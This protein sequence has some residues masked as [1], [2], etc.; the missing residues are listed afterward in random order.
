MFTLK[1]TLWAILLVSPFPPLSFAQNAVETHRNCGSMTHLAEQIAEHPELKTERERIEAQTYD[2]VRRAP[3]VS[4]RSVITIPVVVHVL[5]STAIEN[6]S[7]AQIQSQIDALNRDFRKINTEATRIPAEFQSVAADV[8]LEFCLAKR[9]PNGLPTSGIERLG[10]NKSSWKANDE[11]KR[12]DKGGLDPWDATKYLNIWVCSLNGGALGYAT[13]PGAP[14]SIDGVVIDYRYFG[15]FNTRAPFNLGRTATHEVGHWLNLFHIWGDG[16]C[17]DDHCDD[18]PTHQGAN[19]GCPTYPLVRT[20]C[21]GTNTE[22]SM[23]YMDYTN[24]ACMYMFTNGQKARMLSLFT[25]GGARRSIVEANL[26]GFITPSVCDVP[27][28]FSIANISA[29]SVTVAWT[30][31]TDNA[32]FTIEY[33]RT[34]DLTWTSAVNLTANSFVINDLQ[35][36][37]SYQIRLRSRCSNNVESLESPVL[38]VQTLEKIIIPPPPP[39]AE[40]SDVFEPNNTLSTAYTLASGAKITGLLSDYRDRDWFRI[41]IPTAGTTV[42]IKLSNLPA[43]YDLRLFDNRLHL[44]QTSENQG[45]SKEELSYTTT[46]GQDFLLIYIYGYNGAF[47]P[48]KCYSLEIN[49][50]AKNIEDVDKSSFRLTNG[51]NGGNTEGVVL[52]PNPTTGLVTIELPTI[53]DA[54]IQVFNAMG[55]LVLKSQNSASNRVS[56]DLSSVNNGVYLVRIEQDGQ[57]W[58]KK[59][60]KN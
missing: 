47:H 43:D 7:D 35:S 11:M 44:V 14:L 51:K 60:V 50:F 36:A 29:Q 39:S 45:N 58:R 4:T 34:S 26:C 55:Q 52:S 5:Y 19:Y 31:A 33:R 12:S 48:I 21:G 40:C 15:T 1:Q 32:T 27:T 24:D 59:I 18:T 16:S 23:N 9:Q 38:T 53:N 22:M 41:D 57:V 28:N 37:T 6:I 42:K 30:A 13:F 54:A 10:S 25:V 20:S 49:K 56:I 8:N 3:S 46:S 17:G 2:Y